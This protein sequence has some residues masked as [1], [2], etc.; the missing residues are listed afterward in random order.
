MTKNKNQDEEILKEV[1]K[2]TCFLPVPNT[3][4][5]I[6][7]FTKENFE[8]LMKEALQLKGKQ[9]DK[10]FLEFLE[11]ET[12]KMSFEEL[13]RT[14]FSFKIEELKQKIKETSEEKK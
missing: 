7:A 5:S 1:M 3:E 13:L 8:G 11:E 12:S 10:E 4:L 6:G 14:H 2:W 9:K